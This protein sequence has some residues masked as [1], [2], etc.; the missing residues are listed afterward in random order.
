MPDRGERRAG[1]ERPGAHG[2]LDGRRDGG[3]RVAAD[4]ITFHYHNLYV[5]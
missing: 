3:G 1:R 4:D 5:L 2:V